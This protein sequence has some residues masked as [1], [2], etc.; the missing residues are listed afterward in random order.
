M[1]EK[2]STRS[3][4]LVVVAAFLAYF[5][6]FGYRSAFSVLLTPMTTDMGWDAA[7]VTSGYSIMML[8]YAVTSYFSGMFFTKYGAKFCFGVGTIAGFLG[9]FVTSFAGSFLAYL[10]PYALFAGVATGMLFVPATST[11]RSWFIGNAYGKAFGFAA[12]GGSGD[13]NPGT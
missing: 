2:D 10:V 13:S 8:L 3:G 4:L 9:Y 12:A 7:Q 11:V 6:F 1:S 5:V